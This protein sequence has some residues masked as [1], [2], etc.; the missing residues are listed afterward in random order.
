M[1]CR[2]DCQHE[3]LLLLGDRSPPGLANVWDY[4]HGGVELVPNLVFMTH[5]MKLR[6]IARAINLMLISMTGRG[7]IRM[8]V[9]MVTTTMTMLVYMAIRMRVLLNIQITATTS[10]CS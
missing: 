3:I 9:M 5:V 7:V 6:M 4:P 2:R 1:E 8:V 10:N